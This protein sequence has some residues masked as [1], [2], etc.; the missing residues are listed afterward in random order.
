VPEITPRRDAASLQVAIVVARFNEPVTSGLLAGALAALEEVGVDHPTVVRVPGAFEI[1]V[2]A[3]ALAADHDCVVALGAVVKG[4]TD[5]YE[6]IATQATAGLQQAALR[7]GTPM[8]N[9]ILAVREPGH[10]LAR[11]AP[12]PGNKGREAAE[13]AVEAALLLDAITTR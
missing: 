12:G 13:A 1:P 5:H 6:Q 8:S 3:A 10:A 9:G 2:V 7:T 11:S 4:E